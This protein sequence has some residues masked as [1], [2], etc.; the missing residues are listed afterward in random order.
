MRYAAPKGH[1]ARGVFLTIDSYK[2]MKT[3]YAVGNDGTKIGPMPVETLAV[4]LKQGRISPNSLCFTGGMTTWTPLSSSPAAPFLFPGFG[5][6][7]AKWGL[8]NSTL[9]AFR[10]I[11]TFSGRA[12]RAEYN[13]Y[14]LLGQPLVYIL[15]WLLLLPFGMLLEGNAAAQNIL[16]SIVI[17][18]IVALWLPLLS[19]SVRRL[20]VEA[21]YTQERTNNGKG[22]LCD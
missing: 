19:L 21:G 22:I 2:R 9:S 7:G 11:F 15:M 3:Y 16:G 8:L 6:Q 5:V 18:V 12:S 4:M 14:V 10:K 20:Q 13:Y 1:G 17:I